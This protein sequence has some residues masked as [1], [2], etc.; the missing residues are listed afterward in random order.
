MRVRVARH[1][2]DLEA[3][4]AFY[5]DRVGLPEIG[6]FT[7]HDGYDGVFLDLPGTGAHLEFTTGGG[8]QAP[9]PHPENLLVLYLDDEAAVAK[10]AARINRTPVDPA[11][12]YWRARGLAFADPDGSHLVLVTQQ[13][14]PGPNGRTASTR[15]ETAA[16]SRVR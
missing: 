5:R 11:N 6:R 16:R 8:H 12:P 1:T 7:D 2:E 9:D 13:D 14:H 10:L 3:I 15:P 4:V